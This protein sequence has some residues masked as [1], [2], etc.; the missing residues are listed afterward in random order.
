MDAGA[1]APARPSEAA[2]A[3]RERGRP[4][5]LPA[6]LTSALA[7]DLAFVAVVAL[8][9]LLLRT[10]NLSHFPFGLHGDEAWTGLDARTILDGDIG[11][12]WP[13]TPAALGQPAGPMVWAA[14]WVKLL[15]STILA[16]R[17]P[18]ALLGVGAVVLGFF[19]F[20]ELFGRPTAYAGAVLLA[21]SSWLIFY[22][23][24]GFTASA[25]PFTEM[26]SLLA[27]T[28]ALRKGTWPWSLLA[29]AVVGAGI[30]GYFS[31]PLFAVGLG[32]YVLLY[33]AIERPR[34]FLLQLRNVAVMGLMALL[35]V[36]P[37]FPY[38]SGGGAGYSHDR[39]TFAVNNSAEYKGESSDGG[40]LRVYVHNA[41]KLA[42]TVVVDGI[43][44]AS[45]GSG[46]EAALDP[47]VVAFA[48][49]GFVLAAVFAV[50]RRRAAYLLPF[51]IIPFV[52]IGPLWTV[53]GYQR[54]S[55]GI[56]P[57]VLMAAAVALG[58]AWETVRRPERNAVQLLVMVVSGT[59]TVYGVVEAYR[60]ATQA[61][62]ASLGGYLVSRHVIVFLV[63][64]ATILLAYGWER[65]ERWRRGSAAVATVA[66]A[67]LL[68]VYGA[69]NIYRYFWQVEG[70][71]IMRFTY[72]PELTE[73]SLF[74]KQQPGDT[75]IYFA[76]ERWSAAY[77]TPRYL[78]AGRKL[79]DGTLEDRSDEF[80]KTKGFGDIDRSR[81]A[82]IVLMGKYMEQQDATVGQLYPE[83]T[84]T[85]GVEIVPG[86]P[87][88][89]AYAIPP[90]QP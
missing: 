27:V 81:P 12:I 32:L 13:Y 29:G 83:A 51:I 33:L 5:A 85:A 86:K 77:E 75:R 41:R 30:Y 16:A 56:L 82:V 34:P 50:K 21:G 45:D 63:V 10:I 3:A 88:Y 1:E 44:D 43:G 73:A 53:G 42:Q 23:R 36:R 47:L 58:Y 26:A 66:L 90:R 24:T 49:V 59:L 8:G 4:R 71:A 9:A 68:A 80:G 18:M 17:L 14:L 55:L 15:G 52:L 78:V 37:M 57:F 69:V 22:N 65:F 76:S 39:K 35:V 62:D 84:R 40:R 60:Y 61:P 48:V 6:A 11:Q 46:S 38:F 31:Y 19:A 79:G 25:M 89:V 87:A 20:R 70:T 74:M 67:G 28:V 72:G 7:A 2:P 64:L 54:R